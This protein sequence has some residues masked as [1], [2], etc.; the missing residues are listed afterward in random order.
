MLL[1]TLALSTATVVTV[2][3]ASPASSAECPRTTAHIAVDRDGKLQP[4]KL[5][6][7]PPANAYKAVYR[8]V[9]GCEVPVV[10]RYGVGRR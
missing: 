8:R 10:V 7:L 1:L 3:P 5:N 2:P 4:R 6:E 9:G